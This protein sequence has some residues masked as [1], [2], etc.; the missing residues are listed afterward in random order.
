MR[1]RIAKA[2]LAPTPVIDRTYFHSVYFREPSGILFEIATNPPG[3]SVDEPAERLGEHLM[4]PPQYENARKAIEAVLPPLHAPALPVREVIASEFR[5]EGTSGTSLGFVHRYVPPAQGAK[6]AGRS[7][8]LLLHGTGGDENDL[9]PLGH[10]LL[11]GAGLLSPRGQVLENGAPRFFRRLAAGVFDEADIIRRSDDLAEFIHRA[12]KTYQ[13]EQ[14]GLIVVGFSNGAN[15]AASMLLLHP[16]LVRAAVLFRP[17][18]PI[19]PIKHPNLRH[20][21]VF[22]GGGL[23]DPIAPP[24][25]TEALVTM[26]RRYGASVE[27]HWSRGGHAITPS[28]IDEAGVWIAGLA[29]QTTSDVVPHLVLSSR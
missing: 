4:L 10:T 18:V 13:L 21:A 7:T 28:E 3:F 27:T 16:D 19:R 23:E 24:K 1:S 20:T 9:I 14:D 17:M 11:P 5:S 8:L 15:F 22:I 6:R 12:I 2:G 26:L 25:Q 29:E